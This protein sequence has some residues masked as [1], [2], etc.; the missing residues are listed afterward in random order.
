MISKAE[1]DK[2]QE[3][4]T[5][6]DAPRYQK[7]EFE[8]TGMIRCGLCNSMVT[9]E[10]RTKT[11]QNGNVHH[12]LYYHCT[13]RSKTPCREKSIEEHELWQQVDFALSKLEISERFKDWAIRYLHEYR[14][15][16]A[17]A[18]D[19]ILE[20]KQKELLSVNR[21]LDSLVLKYT[22]PENETGELISAEEYKGLKG[23][24]VQQKIDLEQELNNRAAEKDR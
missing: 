20:A 9:V 7:H 5:R 4:I 18:S 1:F 6:K 14:S 23:N 16:E 17:K 2:A 12:Y 21:Q 10:Q 13:K 22:A 3:Y 11:Q 15:D 19:E 24:L 8:F